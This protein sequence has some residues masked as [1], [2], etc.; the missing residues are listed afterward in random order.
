MNSPIK[1]KQ[2]SGLVLTAVGMVLFLWLVWL[3]TNPV[4]K[5]F[6]RGARNG[7]DPVIMGSA[8]VPLPPEQNHR[9]E[10]RKRA[11]KA[12]KQGRLIEMQ[13][14]LRQGLSVDERVDGGRKTLLMIAAQHNQLKMMR[15]LLSR[16][17]NIA[18]HDVKG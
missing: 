10:Q 16:K 2:T 14:L 18:L 13:A 11:I 6:Q 17:A 12:A 3:F 1:V 4:R 8:P 9:I 15:F 5:E 7:I